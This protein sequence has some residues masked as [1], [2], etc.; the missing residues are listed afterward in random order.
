[1]KNIFREGKSTR[2]NFTYYLSFAETR[3]LMVGLWSTAKYQTGVE[4]GHFPRLYGPLECRPWTFYISPKNIRFARSPHSGRVTVAQ[5]WFSTG[6]FYRISQP[7][8]LN[9]CWVGLP[10]IAK[11]PQGR[12]TPALSLICFCAPE[13]STNCS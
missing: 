13:S 3:I 12:L 2:Q 8:V 4:A 10:P 6:L 5:H 7:L 9:L 11:V 1:L